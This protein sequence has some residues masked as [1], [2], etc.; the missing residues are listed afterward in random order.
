MWLDIYGIVELYF[1][2]VHAAKTPVTGRT[3]VDA[4][5]DIDGFYTD[6]SLDTIEQQ[7]YQFF[8]VATVL[9]AII[10]ISIMV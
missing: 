8:L 6:L 3:L 5:F 10:D 7:A 2:A 9:P 4:D 1:I